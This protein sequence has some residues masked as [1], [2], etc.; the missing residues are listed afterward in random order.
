MSGT[1]V[2]DNNKK[3]WNLPWKVP[4]DNCSLY[5]FCGNF[6]ICSRYNT[7]SPCKCLDGFDPRY[8]DDWKAGRY[9]GGCS[10]KSE[11]SCNQFNITFLN[12]TSMKVDYPYPSPN[13]MTDEEQCRKECLGDCD[14]QAYS[15]GGEQRGEDGCRIWTAELNDLQDYY[16]HGFKLSV[17]VADIELQAQGS[18]RERKEATAV[19]KSLAIYSLGVV[20]FTWKLWM[21]EMAIEIVEPVVLNSLSRSEIL[22]CIHIGLLCVQEDPGDRPTMTDYISQLLC[23]SLLMCFMLP[24]HGRD[25]ITSGGSSLAENETLVS[26]GKTFELGFFQDEQHLNWYVG[27]W[28]YNLNPRTIVWVANRDSPISDSSGVVVVKEDGNL[29]ALDGSGATC[30]STPLDPT[31]SK[32]NRTARLLDSGNLVLIDNL[33]GNTLWQSFDHPADTFLPGMKMD[34]GLTLTSWATSGHNPTN[35]SYTFSQD[36]G[37]KEQYIIHN[38]SVTYWKSGVGDQ[39]TSLYSLDP[40]ASSLLSNLTPNLS[41]Y[42][43]PRLLM[44]S[45]GEIQFYSWDSNK[46]SW[47]LQWFEPHDRCSVYNICG[48]FAICSN[49][50]NNN[51][52]LLCM[53]LPGFEPTNSE[54]W[55][56]NLF[57][58]GCLRKSAISCKQNATRD[59]FL[60]LTSM[61]FGNPD[62]AYPNAKT[63]EACKQECLNT[64]Q[65]QAYSYSALDP[66]RRQRGTGDH[67]RLECRIWTSDI[68]GLQED[69][70]FGLS[71]SVR[72]ASISDIEI[73]WNPPPEPTCSA[74]IDCE[75]WPNSICNATK[76]RQ[77]RCQCKSGFKWDALSLNC[78]SEA[79]LSTERKESS[80]KFRSVIIFISVILALVIFCSIG[81]IIYKRNLVHE[82]KAHFARLHTLSYIG[83][84]NEAWKFW[85]EEKALDMMDPI[86]LSSCNQSEVL[87]CINTGLLCVQEDPNDRPTMSNVVAMLVTENVALSQP[88]QPA[89]VARRRVGDTPSS[90]SSK[91]SAYS[92]N[93]VT[94]SVVE[95]R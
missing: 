26:A 7:E 6:G 74:L 46:T 63:E 64:C 57:S 42:E 49:N 48:K 36:P 12:L 53:C 8:P 43:N 87:K 76:Q 75:D 24:C 40:A 62:S 39:L 82:R 95:G 29:Y 35:G 54:D 79:G 19:L 25:A 83:L 28:Y 73:G 13:S 16:E 41:A 67:R 56:A 93:E 71:L 86:L 65:C 45:S 94:T 23:A 47:S 68:I 81:Y 3:T 59:T 22:K 11:N 78:T 14:C 37:N 50:N 70:T 5:N 27:I 18:S 17:R 69:T 60:N 9:S 4:Q 20:A 66:T 55:G 89:F 88:K 58:G 85:V 32:S 84:E 15:F 90:S 77:G 92:N 72:I 2:W 34:E 30:F 52:G 44:N 61:T 51:N 21:E 80:L 91:K 33:S 38:R 10:R 1:I 31:P